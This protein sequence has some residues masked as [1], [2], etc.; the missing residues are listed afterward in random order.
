MVQDHLSVGREPASDVVVNFPTVSNRHLRLEKQG[1]IYHAID[2]G[3]TNGTTLNGHKLRANVAYP[4]SSGAVLRIGDEA[5][6]S[7]SLTYQDSAGPAAAPVAR[8]LALAG[9]PQTRIGRNPTSDVHLQAPSVSWDHARIDQ[10]AQGAVL[11]DLGSTNG[12]YVNGARVRT[13]RLSPRDRIQI[14]P[15]ILEYQPA[16]LTSTGGSDD[17]R[18]DGLQLR[19]EVPTKGGKT[20]VILNDVSISVAPREFVALVG[21]SGAGKSTL[22]NALSGYRRATSGHVLVNGEDLY[23]SYGQYC[24]Q[25]GYVPQQDIIHRGL[26]V[27]HALRYAAQLRLPSDTKAQEIESRI[28]EVLER[29][30]LTTQRAQLVSELSGGQLKRVSIGSELLIKPGLFFL[31]EPTSGLDPGLDKRM[32]ATMRDLSDEGRTVVLVTHATGNI[33]MCDLVAFLSQGR[34]VFYG[35]PDEAKR[36]FNAIEFADIYA[37]LEP[38]P[39]PQ[40]PNPDLKKIAQDW[41]TRFRQ[42][43]CYQQYVAGRQ[44]GPR[45]ADRKSVV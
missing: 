44:S 42:H 4:L 32:M 25:M 26:P 18:L 31:D 7:V 23:Q 34:L 33:A 17:F 45:A 39:T 36:F 37:Q 9:R 2:L 12:T 15:F 35:P 11:T 28:G 41:E 21:G 8:Q 22:L 30:G 20:K 3:S 5:G 38:A 19:T 10:S 16:Q 43:P 6:N 24:S 14:G 40:N 1:G 29:V 27:D 13:H